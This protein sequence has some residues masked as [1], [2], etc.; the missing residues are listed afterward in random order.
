[1]SMSWPMISVAVTEKLKPPDFVG[2]PDRTPEELNV[3][4]PNEP[5]SLRA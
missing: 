5:D 2:V 3:R 4:P 1:M